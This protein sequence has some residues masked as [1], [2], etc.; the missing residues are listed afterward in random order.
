MTD[1]II[2]ENQNNL[3]SKNR[4]FNDSYLKIL[5][6]YIRDYKVFLIYISLFVTFYILKVQMNMKYYFLNQ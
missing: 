5:I 1:Y 6:D 2:K 3:K 4:F